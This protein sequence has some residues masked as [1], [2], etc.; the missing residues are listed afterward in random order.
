[1]PKIDG[2]DFKNHAPLPQLEAH[3]WKV[4][5]IVLVTFGAKLPWGKGV[6]AFEALFVKSGLKLLE[7]GGNLCIFCS[8]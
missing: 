6:N 8:F 3:A 7:Q 5:R 2:G 4:E 1:M